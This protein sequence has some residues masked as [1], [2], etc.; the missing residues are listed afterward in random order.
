MPCLRGGCP[1]GRR[2][3]ALAPAV[4]SFGHGTGGAGWGGTGW[5]DGTA[6]QLMRRYSEENFDKNVALIKSVQVPP[7][8]VGF[9]YADQDYQFQS[10]EL[11]V[12]S[13][14]LSESIFG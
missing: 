3:R 12:P 2:A 6:T 1:E 14:V 10:L 4:T 7:P 8:V 5:D 11:P 9:V 13:V